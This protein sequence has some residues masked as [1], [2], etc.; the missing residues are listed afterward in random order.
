M[1]PFCDN[2]HLTA[3]QRHFH[4]ILSSV[5]Q[6]VERCIWLLKGRWRKLQFLDHLDIELLVLIIISA[7]VLHNFCLIHD[8]FD[9]GYFGDHD[10]DD[11][12]HGLAHSLLR[13]AQEK[14]MHITVL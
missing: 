3:D 10:E 12:G 11:G 5:R 7:C 2:G 13:R 8:E 14:R 4:Y 1:T 9:E 6:T